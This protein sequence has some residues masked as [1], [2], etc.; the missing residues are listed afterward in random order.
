[1]LRRYRFDIFTDK[2]HWLSWDG[3]SRSITAHIARDGYWYIY[4]EQHRI[5]FICEVVRI[6][7]F[8]DWF[9]FSGEPSHWYRLIGNAVPLLLAEV[10]GTELCCA[11][12]SMF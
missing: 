8:P 9:R 4:L 12:T 10:I 6:Q 3:L 7:I 1:R 2:Y 5:L 11:L